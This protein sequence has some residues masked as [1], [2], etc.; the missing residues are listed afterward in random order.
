MPNPVDRQGVMRLIGFATYLAKFFPNF[1]ELTAPIRSLMQKENEFVW[2]P[3]IHGAAFDKL[4]KLLMN[5]PVLAY[6]NATKPIVIQCN[7]SQ[8]GLGAVLLQDNKP[9]EF[10]SR[11]MTKTEQS[12]AQIEKEQLGICFAME[13]FHTYAYANTNKITVETDHKPRISISK[14]ALSAAPKRLQRM[15][16]RLQRYNYE[17]EFKPG[18]KLIL[19][20]TLSRAYPDNVEKIGTEFPEELAALMDEAQQDQLRMV[21]SKK[22][23]DVIRAAAADD[24]EYQRL[25]SQI[26][27]GWPTAPADVTPD[28]RPYVTFADE[29]VTSD[30]LIF[31][32][33]RVV[34][35]RGARDEI[36][37]RIHASHIGVNGCIRRARESV[38]FPGITNAIKER[39]SKCA[40]CMKAQTETRK[41]PLM[42]H[43][44][45]SR[46]WEKVGIDIFTQRSQ[47]YLVTVDYLSGYFEVDRLPSKKAVDVIYALR[48]QWARHGIPKVCA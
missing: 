40:I 44:A 32:G 6:F 33:H 36:L 10:A 43:P 34:I 12:Y 39:V 2:R 37:S 4:K 35:P 7:A 20:D 17:L 28:L 3:E 31:K 9:V 15:L 8:A 45:P 24:M 41:E 30:G 21:A 13:R 5:A 11:A 46:P 38:Y 1:S 42:S 25:K 22:T 27:V 19:A 48:Q 23:I 47:D 29:L 14:K 18:C 16:L 26:L